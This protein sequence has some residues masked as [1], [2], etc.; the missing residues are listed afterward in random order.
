MTS[1]FFRRIF[2]GHI[3]T[4]I[5]LEPQF[6][7]GQSFHGNHG[8]KMYGF[9]DIVGQSQRWHHHI[10]NGCSYFFQICQFIYREF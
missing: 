8:L 2:F 10:S 7:T 3:L 6:N 9:R 1:S 4:Y 5:P